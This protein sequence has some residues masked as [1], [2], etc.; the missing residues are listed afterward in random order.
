MYMYICILVNVFLF[1]MKTCAHMYT[2]ILL[3]TPV[4]IT[5]YTHQEH[6]FHFNRV[7]PCTV[8]RCAYLELVT[9]V[10]AHPLVAKQRYLQAFEAA[11][12]LLCDARRYLLESDK[13]GQAPLQED[14]TVSSC[15]LLFTCTY[16]L[17]DVANFA[18]KSRQTADLCCKCLQHSSLAVRLYVLQYISNHGD[19]LCW[20]ED[21]ITRLLVS[22]V[23]SEV[24]EGILAVLYQ[25]LAKAV[26]E[27]CLCSELSMTAMQL[28]TSTAL[29]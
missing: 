10:I 29:R 28:V 12:P 16:Q 26:D 25:V 17:A 14:V 2:C 1:I 27:K 11:V 15:K 8:T 9:A 23:S 18:T 7:N 13:E 6:F 21:G 4:C 19:L 24:D 20:K 5:I 3:T 22:L